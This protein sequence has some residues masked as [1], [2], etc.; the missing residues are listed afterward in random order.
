MPKTKKKKS[1]TQHETIDPDQRWMSNYVESREKEQIHELL[2][3]TNFIELNIDYRK[4]SI[5]DITKMI[6]EELASVKPRWNLLLVEPNAKSCHKYQSLK[7]Y[8]G[9]MRLEM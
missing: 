1:P 4:A 8:I 7:N 6:I 9:E 5:Q 3:K 2:N